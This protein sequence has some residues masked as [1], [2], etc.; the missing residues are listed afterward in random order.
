MHSKEGIN[1]RKRTT[2]TFGSRDI[3]KV[4]LIEIGVLNLRAASC[5]CKPGT[6]DSTE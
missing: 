3:Y 5:R 1:E 6:F 2:F 4:P